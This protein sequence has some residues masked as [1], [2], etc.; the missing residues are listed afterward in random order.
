MYHP[1][2]KPAKKK[3]ITIKMINQSI[4]QRG[5]FILKKHKF[6]FELVK[7]LLQYSF[8]YNFTVYSGE[9]QILAGNKLYLNLEFRTLIGISRILL[10]T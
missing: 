6:N 7:F 9:N 5:F 4:T 3:P 8:L 2:Q 1:A 10:E